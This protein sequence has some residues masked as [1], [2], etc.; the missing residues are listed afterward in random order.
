MV[1]AVFLL[2]FGCII[3]DSRNID[4]PVRNKPVPLWNTMLTAYGIL[5]FQF[6]IHPTILTI[7]VDMINKKEIHKAVIGAFSGAKET[8]Y[9]KGTT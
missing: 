4:A 6:D 3:F 2:V 8:F 7:Q 5:A 1:A 9:F